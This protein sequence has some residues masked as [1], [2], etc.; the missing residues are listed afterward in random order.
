MPH[1][2]SR[3]AAAA[4]LISIAMGCAA[5]QAKDAVEYSTQ[6][7]VEA[8]VLS[9]H[10][11]E[12]FTGTVVSWDDEAGRGEVQL[13]APAVSGRLVGGRPEV[14]AELLVRVTEADMLTGRIEFA[15]A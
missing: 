15:P 1:P 12:A 11:G 5:A 9:T 10:I 6:E 4:L 2:R 14:G 13:T 7:L 3:P 8:L